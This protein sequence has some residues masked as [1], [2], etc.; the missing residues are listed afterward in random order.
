MLDRVDENQKIGILIMFEE[1]VQRFG[2]KMQCEVH[3]HDFE[4]STFPLNKYFTVTK[5]TKNKDPGYEAPLI[6]DM[7]NCDHGPRE[8]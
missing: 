4:H 7:Q 5:Q 2:F 3:L 1:K 8:P 6:K